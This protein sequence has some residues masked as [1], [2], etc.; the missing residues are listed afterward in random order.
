MLKSFYCGL[1]IFSLVKG[2]RPPIAENFG[3]FCAIFAFSG[4]GT[5]FSMARIYRDG[6]VANLF[7]T[8]TF[9]QAIKKSESVI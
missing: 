7:G 2:W 4:R 1:S 3:V 6:K 5:A 8:S 9:T